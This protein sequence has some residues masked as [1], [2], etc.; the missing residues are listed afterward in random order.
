MFKAILQFFWDLD[1][2][3]RH[4]LSVFVDSLATAS[5]VSSP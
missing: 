5:G 2:K 1:P 3:L 4:G